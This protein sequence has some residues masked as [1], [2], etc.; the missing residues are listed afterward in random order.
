MYYA[1][2]HKGLMSNEDPG[3]F[4]SSVT[5]RGWNDEISTQPTWL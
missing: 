1:R 4:V 5:R 2:H 3:A